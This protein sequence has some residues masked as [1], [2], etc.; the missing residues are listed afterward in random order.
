VQNGLESGWLVSFDDN[1]HFEKLGVDTF[2]FAHLSFDKWTNCAVCRRAKQ[3]TQ[4]AST[5]L[6]SK[7]EELKS[8]LRGQE[9]EESRPRVDY[10]ILDLCHDQLSDGFSKSKRNSTAIKQQA[11]PTGPRDSEP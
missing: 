9:E 1:N 3:K 10:H 11:K 8:L 2:P 7:W 5:R 4:H 6:D